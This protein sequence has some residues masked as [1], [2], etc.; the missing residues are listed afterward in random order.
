M[1]E[2]VYTNACTACIDSRSSAVSEFVFFVRMAPTLRQS[3]SARIENVTYAMNNKKQYEE[4]ESL[5]E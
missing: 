2:L 1:V 5:K 4:Y 3:Q